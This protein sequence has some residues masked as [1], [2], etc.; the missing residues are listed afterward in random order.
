MQ[1]RM[2]LLAYRYELSFV[3]VTVSSSLT[4]NAAQAQSVSMLSLALFCASFDSSPEHGRVC[5]VWVPM[6]DGLKNT[7]APDLSAPGHGICSVNMPSETQV[8]RIRQATR[9]IRCQ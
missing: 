2:R 8:Y 6:E 4:G 9:R 1:A 3:L 5:P 7:S